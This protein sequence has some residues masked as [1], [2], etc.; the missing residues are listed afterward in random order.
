ME[1]FGTFN[2][3]N[4]ISFSQMLGQNSWWG[5]RLLISLVEFSTLR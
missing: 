3:T 1:R 2:K 4:V 5:A